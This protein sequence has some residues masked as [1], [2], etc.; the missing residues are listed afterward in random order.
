MHRLLSFIAL[1]L[2]LNTASAQSQT[3]EP[4]SFE[5]VF[6]EDAP[7]VDGH[8]DDAIWDLVQP[9]DDFVQRWPNE[10]AEPTEYSWAKVAYDRDNLY[11]AFNFT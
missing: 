6:T 10:G 9:M 3:S 7:R 1:T 8:L 5:A 11:F 4:P 2:L